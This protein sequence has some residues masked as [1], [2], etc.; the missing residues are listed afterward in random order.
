MVSSTATTL[1]NCLKVRSTCW[2]PRLRARVLLSQQIEQIG[3]G[4]CRNAQSQVAA[5]ASEKKP[6]STSIK[7]LTPRKQIKH[8]IRI[9]ETGM[10]SPVFIPR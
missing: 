10:A 6:R 2:G 4:K 9:N 8:N 5:S 3:K 1:N 7:R